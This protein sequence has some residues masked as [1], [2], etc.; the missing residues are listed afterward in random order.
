MVGLLVFVC[1][2]SFKAI[3]ST[4]TRLRATFSIPASATK[5]KTGKKNN[6]SERE[7]GGEKGTEHFLSDFI[8]CQCLFGSLTVPSRLS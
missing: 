4:F 7:N 3:A 8:F 6:P 5:Q 1:V 2:P